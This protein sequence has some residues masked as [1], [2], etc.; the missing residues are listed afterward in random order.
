M[1]KFIYLLFSLAVLLSSCNKALDVEPTASISP[2]VAIT[3]KA[4]VGKAL[5]GCYNSLQAV[6]LYGRNMIIIGDLAADN[7]DWTGTT[8]EYQQILQ[9]NIPANNGIVEGIW[10]A[11]YDGIN[12]VNN[13]LW[14]LPSINDMTET[15]KAQTSGELYFLRALCYFRLLNHFGG[16]PVKTE[17]TLDLSNIDQAKNSVDAVY[18]QILIDLSIAESDLPET[19]S[20]G[21]A[22]KFSAKALLAKV[23]LTHYHYSNDANS[24]VQAIARA[25]DVIASEKYSLATSYADLFNGANSSESVFEVVYDAQNFNRLAQY[26][27]PRSLTGRYEIAPS[28]PIISSYE[29]G[30]NRFD[31]SIA[32]DSENKVYATKY[33]EVASGAD[34][35]YVFRLAEM[36]M[37][38][39]EALAYS[40]GD[41]TIIQDDINA[42][43]QRAGL[44]STEASNYDQLKAAIAQEKRIEFAFEGH[45]WDDIVRTKTASTLLGIDPKYYLFPIPLSEM[46]T[47]KLM[48]QNDG[49]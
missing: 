25:T 44:Q 21:R 6:G 22:N 35:V 3:N 12:R 11:A 48:K 29:T 34:R 31:V 2:D 46:Q 30:D 27:Y 24:A 4:G 14:R 28:N 1:K 15:E 49:Y 7:L 37:I 47:N 41:I 16:V 13:V 43:R 18:N 45:R 40:A 32:Y 10:A 39:A 33:N 17:P 8:Y 42:I 36:H 5:A 38:R 23:Y 26:F 20:L 19:S 9:H